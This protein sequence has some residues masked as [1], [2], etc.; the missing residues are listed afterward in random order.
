[1]HTTFQM[2]QDRTQ[3]VGFREDGNKLLGS[4]KVGNFMITW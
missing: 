2:V 4:T 1:L 3:Q